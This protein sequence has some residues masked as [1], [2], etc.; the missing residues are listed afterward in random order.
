MRTIMNSTADMPKI[1]E[2]PF[3]DKK[4]DLKIELVNF[5]KSTKHFI[6]Q[7]SVINLESDNYRLFLKG[8]CLTLVVSEPH[9]YSR[10]IHIHDINW[11]I[12]NHQ[13]YEVLKHSEII[14]PGDNFYIVRHFAYP[15]S[16]LLEVI[17]GNTYGNEI[18][19]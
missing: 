18:W 19:F 10:P 8:S 5:Q 9:E 11:K 1:I 15:E 2:Y 16:Q 17:L 13:S 4:D 14:L 6:L 3:L 7:L 12:Y